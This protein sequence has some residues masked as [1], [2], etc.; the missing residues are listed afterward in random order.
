MASPLRALFRAAVGCSL[1]QKWTT[2]IRSTALDESAQSSYCGKGVQ[3]LLNID[4]MIHHLIYFFSSSADCVFFKCGAIVDLNFI[5]NKTEVR[6]KICL[7]NSTHFIS[8]KQNIIKEI[9]YNIYCGVTLFLKKYVEN[10]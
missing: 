9:K 1:T 2:L 5:H 7:Q 3:V 4:L 10:K 8:L 6:C